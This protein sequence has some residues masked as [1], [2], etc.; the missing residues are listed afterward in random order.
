MLT[1]DVIRAWE[2]LSNNL[3]GT[4]LKKLTS[5]GYNDLA[6]MNYNQ[7]IRIKE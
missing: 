5:T 6:N 2:V 7:T 4:I 3:D 1:D